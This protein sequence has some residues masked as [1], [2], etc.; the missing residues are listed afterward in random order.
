MAVPEQNKIYYV[1]SYRDLASTPDTPELGFWKIYPKNGAWY[2]LDDTGT[3]SPL[4]T[5]GSSGTPNTISMFTSPTSL[6]DGTWAFS[7]NDIYPLVNGSN[8]GSGTSPEFRI[9]TIYMASDID[10]LSTLSLKENGTE[11]VHISAGGNVGIGTATP[12]ALLDI[13]GLQF[14]N[15]S[16]LQS[17]N[18]ENITITA[19]YGDNVGMAAVPGGDLVL[20]SGGSQGT[21]AGNVVIDTTTGF[22]QGN[23][24]FAIN[25]TMFANLTDGNFSVGNGFTGT[26]RFNVKG[27]GATSATYGLKI[28]NLSSTKNLYVG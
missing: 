15:N 14:S 24:Q 7:G 3:E 27:S 12:G 1:P 11:R 16:V 22:S 2:I 18:G 9:G 13:D 20:K 4:D 17:I 6:G 23:I 10:Y 26:G 21:N 28:E 25:G 5:G 8:I 19:G